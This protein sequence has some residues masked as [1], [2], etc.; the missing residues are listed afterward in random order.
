MD[1]LKHAGWPCRHIIQ[2]VINDMYDGIWAFL[3]LLARYLREQYWEESEHHLA[4]M[5]GGLLSL[6]Y[7]CSSY[8]SIGLSFMEG[9]TEA[10]NAVALGS[11]DNVI[12]VN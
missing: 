9:H 7:A 6:V 4:Q 10:K 3:I 12:L 1:F 5:V 2:G 11:N 8:S